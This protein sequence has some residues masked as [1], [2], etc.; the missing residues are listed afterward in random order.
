MFEASLEIDPHN[1]IALFQY[2][3]ALEKAENYKKARDMLERIDFDSMEKQYVPFFYISL[4]R[5]CYLLKRRTDGNNYFD[6]AIAMSN[7]WAETSL[8][9]AKNLLVVNPYNKKAVGLLKEVVKGYYGYQQARQILNWHMPMEDLYE[10]WQ[11]D[12]PVDDEI[13]LKDT[14]VLATA[15]RHKMLNEI[16]LLRGY[17]EKIDEK[18]SDNLAMKTAHN[19]INAILK[20]AN[21]W[22][23][24]EKR[25]IKTI[26][27][28]D[29]KSMLE[30]IAAISHDVGDKVGQQFFQLVGILEKAQEKHA[31]DSETYA[32]LTKVLERTKLAAKA[33]KERMHVNQ[34]IKF[35][36]KTF[37]LA[38]LFT[39]WQDK[40]TFKH[41]T[42]R[43]KLHDSKAEIFGDE[44]KIRGFIHE[45]IENSVK[46]N[47][48]KTDLEINIKTWDEVNPTI[49]TETIPHD[50][51]Y[52]VISFRDNGKGVP[53]K[54]KAWVFQPLKSTAHEGGGLGL[55]IIKR[56]LSLMN[57]FITESGIEGEGVYFKIYILCKRKRK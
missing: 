44:S 48:N 14:E 17:I 18:H 35:S 49:A 39:G 2:A 36:K 53:V 3:L 55:F 41:A 47:P 22:K 24:D 15:I 10:A 34:G 21:S 51:K 16:N 12:A 13:I 28:D 25:Q 27:H 46:H 43:L 11:H 9:T 31:P 32:L 45:L 37:T 30:I 57:G 40:D 6:K 23:E 26:A 54:K 7:N 42:I 1:Y 50:Q 4:G 52:I 8:Y 19:K 38:E 5:L 20:I 29:I 33:L 56:T